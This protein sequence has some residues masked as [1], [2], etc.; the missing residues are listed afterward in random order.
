MNPTIG[1]I[2]QLTTTPTK[3][4]RVPYN[5]AIPPT[6]NYIERHELS[7]LSLLADKYPAKAIEW[8][9]RGLEKKSLT[10]ANG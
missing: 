1:K 4:A 5:N 7:L 9:N 3:L 2:E 8:G 10:E 6:V